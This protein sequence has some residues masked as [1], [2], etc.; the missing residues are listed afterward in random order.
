MLNVL[1]KE[2]FSLKNN[3][4]HR[5][6]YI[7]IVLTFLF[8]L[9]LLSSCSKNHEN[10]KT[11]TSDNEEFPIVIEDQIGRKITIKELPERIISLSPSNTEIIYALGLE[12]RLVGVTEYCDYPEDAKTKEK[13]GGYDEP[14][15]EKIFSLE[16]D[17]VIA[18]TAHQK[19]VEQIEKLDIPC[20]VLAPKNIDEMLDSI[21]IIGKA[22]GAK[23]DAEKL[24]YD[25]KNRIKNI[26]K[27]T[28][29]TPEAKRP[30]VYYELWHSPIM[31]VGPGT[32]IDDIIHRA[33]GK[34][35]ASDAD[36]PY[37]Q[38]SQ[39]QVLAKNPEIIIYSYHGS[40]KQSKE[41][42][43][44]RPGWETI[45]AIKNDKVFYINEDILI[46]P[47]PRLIDG[48]EEVAKIIH[49]EITK[50]LGE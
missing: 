40:S 8:V 49:P 22:S 14:N 7:F 25:L 4:K 47:T 24:V 21:V 43:L 5:I 23:S 45:S 31:T 42:I 33:G 36:K 16:P 1:G 2:V 15:L 19:A 27:Y 44:E 35:I 39:E 18:T 41:D 38:Y 37:P 29:D 13:I 10:G 11:L 3:N 48:L 34:N 32:F 30:K 46:R 50:K 17:L 26:E 12:D 6:R 9:M 20:I 28:A